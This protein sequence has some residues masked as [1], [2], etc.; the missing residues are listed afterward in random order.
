MKKQVCSLELEVSFV[1][2]NDTKNELPKLKCMSFSRL[3]IEKAYREF[4]IEKKISFKELF[5]IKLNGKLDE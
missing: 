1:K 2:K 3:E 4:P 5:K